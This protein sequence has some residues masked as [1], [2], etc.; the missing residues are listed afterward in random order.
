VDR[1]TEQL[2]TFTASYSD[3]VLVDPVREAALLHLVDSIACAVA[4]FDSDAAEVAIRLAREE[5]HERGALVFGAGVRTT[6]ELAAFANTIMVRAWDWNDGMTAGGGGH[7]SDMIPALL[8]I[9]ERSGATPRKVL[10][11][12]VLAYELLGALGTAAPIREYG[13]DQGTFMAPSVAL[14]LGHLLELTEAQLAS[15]MSLA[16]VPHLP[17]FVTRVGQLSMWK[18]CSTA[19]AVR[20]AIFATRLAREGMTGPSEPFEGKSGVFAQVTN[21]PFEL[22]LPLEPGGKTVIEL[23]Y[24]KLFPAEGPSQALLGTIPR[25]RQFAHHDDIEAIE[26]ETYGHAFRTMADPTKWDPSTRETAD[27]S[28]P[29]V[30]AVGLVDGEITRASFADARIADPALRPVMNKITIAENP[31]FT[32]SYGSVG[33]T[34]SGT[35]R[36]RVTVRTRSGAVLVEDVTY[37]K[38]HHRNPM[39]VEDVDAKL[40]AAC[41]GIVDKAQR[42]EIRNAWWG[43]DSVDDL[44]I[45]MSTVERFS[46][47]SDPRHG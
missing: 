3:S 5:R 14:A 25:I 26:I 31:E 37:P 8:A 35:P 38:G 27:H 24:M 41:A 13:W 40:D 33:G 45:P 22:A 11:S 9:G 1:I 12:I 29:Y 36:A 32:K 19:G 15:A 6:P 30:L 46:V 18:G 43:F 23:S 7:P 28:L 42:E 16:M 39:T 20:N 17:L 2:V 4:G 34:L 44:S 10:T 47:Q 21:G